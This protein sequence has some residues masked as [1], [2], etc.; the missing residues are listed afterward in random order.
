M[1]IQSMDMTYKYIPGSTYITYKYD[2]DG[3]K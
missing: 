1:K 2:D 3:D